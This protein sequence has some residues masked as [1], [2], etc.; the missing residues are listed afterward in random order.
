MNKCDEDLV[1]DYIIK[2]INQN[3]LARK[4]Q[5]SPN[6]VKNRLKDLGFNK[7]NK[8]EW[9]GDDFGTWRRLSSRAGFTEEEIRSFISDYSDSYANNLSIDFS[10]CFIVRKNSICKNRDKWRWKF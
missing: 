3:D 2:G 6:K 10:Y 7:T 1:Y 4:Y 5:S 8:A 9:E